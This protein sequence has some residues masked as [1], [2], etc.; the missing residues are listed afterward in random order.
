M[1]ILSIDAS[2]K[3]A[4]CGVS[5]DGCIVT[6]RFCA[7]GLTHSQT[8]LP[9]ISEMLFEAKID[10]DDI[11]ELALTVG[12]GSFTGLRIGAA[13]A[14]GLAGNRLCRCVSTL[15]AI[16][17]NFC[18]ENAVV[19]PALDARRNQVYTATF[20]CKKSCVTRLEDDCAKS[21]TDTLDTIKEYAKDNTVYIAG[22]GAYLFEDLIC[23]IEN[24]EIAKDKLLY[25][26]AE[27]I[28][29]ASKNSEAIEAKNIKLSYLRLSQAE[30]ELKEKQKND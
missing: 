13:T 10:V 20:K 28:E 16:A 5:E 23:G 25:P 21:V 7:S 8:L 6:N 11:D 30:R 22:D 3:T 4:A 24:V 27:G 1:K 15:D 9:M 29:K 2:G 17:H 26:Q 18:N 19:I 12:P 14:M